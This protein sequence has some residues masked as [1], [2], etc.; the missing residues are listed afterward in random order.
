MRFSD[1]TL[2]RS[3]DRIRSLAWRCVVMAGSIGDIGKIGKIGLAV[4][5]E[6]GPPDSALTPETHGFVSQGFIKTTANNYLAESKRGSFE[7]TEVGIN[8]TSQLNERL[9]LGVQ[10][11]ARQLGNT[12]PPP[13]HPLAIGTSLTLEEAHPAAGRVKLPSVS[14]TTQ[15][16][17]ARWFRS[18]WRLR[19]LL[20]RDFLLRDRGGAYG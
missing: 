11:F 3:P 17:D 6:L 18:C 4:A 14:T 16:V 20:P 8:F 10:L 2:H 1:A 7:F 12:C 15:D 9:L 13:P 5:A 19:L